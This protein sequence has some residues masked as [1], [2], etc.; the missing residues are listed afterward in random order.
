MVRKGHGCWGK[1]T[2]LHVY[3]FCE[4]ADELRRSV[5]VF[6]GAF[7]VDVEADLVPE[8]GFEALEITLLAVCDLQ[9]LIHGW[10]YLLCF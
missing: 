2:D 3:E 10:K 1:G 4:G 6:G 7:G 5:E 9:M 8:G